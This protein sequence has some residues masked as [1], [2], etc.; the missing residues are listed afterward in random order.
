MQ[1]LVLLQ[2]SLRPGMALLPMRSMPIFPTSR[3]QR[4]QAKTCF[5]AE[6]A[7][8]KRPEAPFHA[9]RSISRDGHFLTERPTRKSLSAGCGAMSRDAIACGVSKLVKSPESL[10]RS[11]C[12]PQRPMGTWQSSPA[13]KL[14]QALAGHHAP[15]LAG[16]SMM[17]I[18]LALESVV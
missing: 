15:I 4:R 2:D 11:P 3:A 13:Q 17:F 7:P 12:S 6:R 10:L 1:V 18:I 16:E 8:L 5:P 9:P 14:C